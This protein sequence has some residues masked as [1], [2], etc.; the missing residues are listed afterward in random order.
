ME[1]DI[2]WLIGL[3]VTVGAALVASVIAAF[4]SLAARLTRNN[5]I[6]HSRIDD[7][8]DNYVRRVDLDGHLSRWDKRMDS[9]ESKIDRLLEK[10]KK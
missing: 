3:I 5:A 2:K 1:Q 10:D 8:K 9:I 7:V 4:R 6:L